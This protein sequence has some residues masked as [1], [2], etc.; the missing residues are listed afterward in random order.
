MVQQQNPDHLLT[1]L[2]GAI[3]QPPLGT[4]VLKKEVTSSLLTGQELI[5]KIQEEGARYKIEAAKEVEALRE[6]AL[7]E[8]FQEGYDK[9]LESIHRLEEEIQKVRG[10]VE[11]Q[12]VPVAVK[13]AQKIVARELEAHP[14]TIIDIVKSHLKAVAQHKKFTVYVSRDEFDLLDKARHQLKEKLESL[15]AFSVRAR[16][17]LQKGSVVIETEAGIVNATIE[18]QWARIEKAFQMENK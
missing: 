10:Q 6:Q 16:D 15:E 17:D 7:Q 2:E 13:A 8:G 3:V 18:N 1:L 5:Q 9:W 4:K 11:K 14:E 12:I